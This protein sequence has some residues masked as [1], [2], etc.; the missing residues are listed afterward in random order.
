MKKV[1]LIFILFLSVNSMI[2]QV[3]SWQWAKSGGGLLTEYG[4]E[5]AVD[6]SGNV[7][8]TGSFSSPD[9]LIDGVTLT[10]PAYENVFVVKFNS[11]GNLQWAR[12]TTSTM[13]MSGNSI[14][15]DNS[16]AIYI[17][18]R[19]SGD[20]VVFGNSIIYNNDPLFSDIFLLKYDANGNE[21]W[22]VSGGGDEN[23]YITEIDIDDNGFVFV[24]GSFFSALFTMGNVSF[25]NCGI[26]STDLFLIKFDGNGATLWGKS[27]CGYLDESASA[28]ATDISGNVYITG[29]FNSS[30]FYF[31]TD[32]LYNGTGAIYSD[33]YVVKFDSAGN[34]LWV[35]S[36]P[37]AFNQSVQGIAVDIQENVYVAGTFDQANFFIAG[38]ILPHTGATDIF[39]VRYDA[40]GNPVWAIGGGGT[41]SDFPNGIEIDPSGQIIMAGSFY[42]PKLNLGSDSIFSAG[43]QD[44]FVTRFDTSGNFDWI[45]G[46]GD[47]LSDA[48]RAVSVDNNGDII[49]TGYY[50]SPTIA[51]GSHILTNVLASDFYVAK[52][53]YNVGLTEDLGSNSG[54][55]LYPNPFSESIT[56]QSETML[57]NALI[58]IFDLQGKLV[59]RLPDIS[60]YD[61]KLNFTN[62]QSGIYHLR[63]S[64]ANGLQISN[65]KISFIKSQY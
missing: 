19:F 33:F 27:P 48:N 15:V 59:C 44:I 17:G 7:Y 9:I 54:I 8:V 13:V 16:G 39:L 22:A 38:S 57:N 30:P 53:S 52:L 21:L 36:V 45:I 46:A 29:N 51:F 40:S 50:Y 3:P 37:S 12:A 47:T 49:I 61:F 64:D 14:V 65:Q 4:L 56:L 42:S 6:D 62:Q 63:L 43:N 58:E 20:S 34:T 31:E 35:L 25:I 11:A 26:N 55:N 1:A 2:A 41:E 5:T 23:D 28:I 24:T 32:T 60:G 10:N 18:G